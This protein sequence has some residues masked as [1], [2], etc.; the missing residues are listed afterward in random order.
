MQK[1]GL[2]WLYRFYKEPK[3][4]FR[5]YFIE[6]PAIFPLIIKQRFSQTTGLHKN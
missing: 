1:N 3:R 6:A 2:E 5:R 4:L